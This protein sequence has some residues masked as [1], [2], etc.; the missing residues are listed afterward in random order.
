MTM[1]IKDYREMPDDGLF[2]KIQ[3]RLAVRRA[4]RIGGVVAAVAAVVTVAAIMLWPKGQ[5]AEMAAVQQQSAAPVAV[6]DEPQ[7]MPVAAA[8]PSAK[9]AEPMAVREEMA[10]QPAVA[11]AEEAEQELDAAALLPQNTPVVADL[12][13]PQ[14]NDSREAYRREVG[15]MP[16]YIGP[17]DDTVKPAIVINTTAAEAKAGAPV[18]HY[19]NVIWAPNVI[20]PNG[21]VEDNRTFSIK[22]TSEISDFHMHIYNRSGRRIFM[23]TDPAFVWDATMGGT[24]VPQGAYVWVATFRDSD[25]E[26]RMEK[27]TVTVIR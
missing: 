26:P 20:I 10:V 14:E 25:G 5:E 15:C 12:K 11:Q 21:D 27:G 4:M 18:T 9:I 19:D 1:N 24:K 8:E 17:A 2:E 22:A 7:S 13:V 23:S 6:A 16:V 3:R